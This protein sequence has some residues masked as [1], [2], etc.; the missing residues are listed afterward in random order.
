MTVASTWYLLR[1]PRPIVPDS[2]R[3]AEP[4][5]GAVR[6]WLSALVLLTGLWGLALF[7][8]DAGPSDLIWVWPGDL[9][10]SR[11][12]GVMLLTIAAG[13]AYS[14]R[15]ADTARTMLAMVVTY[16]LG[17]AVASLWNLLAAKPIKPA[18]LVVFGVICLGSVALMVWER[19]KEA[20]LQPGS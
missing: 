20:L 13:S 1:P 17:L 16:A 12:I 7:I 3:D 9:L 19:P 6:A 11:L 15:H 8:T 14:L 5:S 4:S 2:P 18:Y 10:S